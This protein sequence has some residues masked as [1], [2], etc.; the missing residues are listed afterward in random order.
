MCL[1]DAENVWNMVGLVSRGVVCNTTSYPA[2][3]TRVSSFIGFI[4]SVASA[5]KLSSS[6]LT[7]HNCYLMKKYI[8]GM[9]LLVTIL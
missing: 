5:G 8:R 7:A 6:L 1:N 3:Y 9:S 2:I 4:E